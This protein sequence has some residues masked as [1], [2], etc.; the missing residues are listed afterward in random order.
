[1]SGR[2]RSDGPD[3]Q[4]QLCVAALEQSAWAVEQIWKVATVLT[5]AERKS[6]AIPPHFPW[7]QLEAA[8]MALG[9][10]PIRRLRDARARRALA[11]LQASLAQTRPLCVLIVKRLADGEDAAAGLRRLV[12]LSDQQVL[13]LRKL[14]VRLEGGAREKLGRAQAP[15][16]P[17]NA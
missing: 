5:A 10:I 8:D 1:M 7:P 2:A 15:A 12:R 14:Q 17:R 16:R 4:R 9:A 11:S 3:R 6:L 13:L